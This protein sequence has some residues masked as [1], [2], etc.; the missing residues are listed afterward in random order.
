MDWLKLESAAYWATFTVMFLAVAAWESRRPERD[1]RVPAGRRWAVHGAL[2]LLGAAFRIAVL[3]LSLV[4][5][6]LLA[7]RN[8]WGLFHQF[9]APLWI[10]LPVTVLLL[11]FNHYVTHRLFHAIP[12][13]W[14]VHR[15]HHSDPD[16]DV[17]TGLRFHPLEPLLPQ[18][19]GIAVVLALGAPPAA[20]LTAT[21]LA[22]AINFAEHANANLPPTWERAL[23]PWLVTSRMHRIHHSTQLRHQQTNFGELFPWWDRMAGTYLRTE[24]RLDVGLPGYQDAR[25]VGLP[26][27]LSQPF[28]PSR[29]P[30]T[31]KS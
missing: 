8:G 30:R 25:S 15:V 1:W 2:L 13:L 20:V 31:A 26:E 9:P 6:A 4:G 3:R 11:D 12:W 14:R 19:G 7:A 27:L 28:Q 24:E 17:S 23:A 21:V 10:A 18:L 22:A 5:A 29:A 16:F